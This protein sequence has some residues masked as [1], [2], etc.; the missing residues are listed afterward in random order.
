LLLVERL[1]RR[2]LANAVRPTVTSP[3]SMS[4]GVAV[5]TGSVG[6]GGGAALT[7]RAKALVAVA[8]L[9]SVTRTLKL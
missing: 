2:T 9:L 6:G 7:F 4:D 8:A 3:K 1:V 5:K